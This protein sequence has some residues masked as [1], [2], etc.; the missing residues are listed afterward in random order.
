MLDPQRLTTLWG[1]TAGYRV[2][3]TVYT[4]FYLSCFLLPLSIFIP[5]TFPYTIPLSVYKE[6]LL[7]FLPPLFLLLFLLPFMFMLS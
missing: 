1:S 4:Y 3:F 6:T 5:S 2:G 7:L